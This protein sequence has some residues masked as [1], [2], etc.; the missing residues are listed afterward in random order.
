MGAP[1][2]LGELKLW[3]MG[4]KIFSCVILQLSSMNLKL[5]KYCKTLCLPAVVFAIKNLPKILALS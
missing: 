1:K 3:V 5:L 2:S 4:R